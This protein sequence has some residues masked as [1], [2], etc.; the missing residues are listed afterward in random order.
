M[1]HEYVVISSLM[2]NA[3]QR[4][5]KEYKT[6]GLT[7][8]QIAASLRFFKIF[9]LSL[10]LVVDERKEF[11]SLKVEKRLLKNFLE[12]YF[13]CT[14]SPFKLSNSESIEITML[15]KMEERV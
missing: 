14:L 1:R 7:A 2:E 12:K 8:W 3:Y 9:R 4:V 10:P 5:L 15:S 11:E 6:D 13:E